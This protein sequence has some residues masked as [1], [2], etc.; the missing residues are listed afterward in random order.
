VCAYEQALIE[1]LIRE[2]REIGLAYSDEENID[3]EEGNAVTSSPHLRQGPQTLPQPPQ[4]PQPIPQPPQGP[5][6]YPPRPR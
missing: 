5:Q 2:C 1:Q 6:T 4:G 3:Q